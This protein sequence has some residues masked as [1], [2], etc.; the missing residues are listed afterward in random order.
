MGHVSTPPRCCIPESLH[1]KCSKHHHSLIA[2][3]LTSCNALAA[4]ITTTTGDNGTA[5]LVPLD[6]EEVYDKIPG[7]MNLSKDYGQLGILWVTSQRLCWVAQLQE[8][9]NCS[10]PYLQVCTAQPTMTC[11][12][13][14]GCV[15]T[16]G[17]AGCQIRSTTNVNRRTTCLLRATSASFDRPCQPGA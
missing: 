2:A 5:E 16:T 17:R 3:C 12:E 8:N 11:H 14:S 15:G 13:V 6:K 10:L 9:Y 4:N 7:V 1:Y